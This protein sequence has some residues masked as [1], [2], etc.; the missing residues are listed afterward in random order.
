VHQPARTARIVR[1]DELDENADRLAHWLSRPVG[2]RIRHVEELR[3]MAVPRGSRDP[4][5]ELHSDHRDL[6][7]ILNAK[8]VAYVVVGGMAVA[9]HGAPRFTVDLDL[10]VHDSFANLR[11]LAN[12]LAQSGFAAGELA[13]VE[14]LD[15]TRA[16]QLGFEPWRIDLLSCLAG[17]TWDE[18]AAGAETGDFGVPAPVLGRAELIRNKR[19]VG[20][21]QDLADIARLGG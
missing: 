21:P 3:R 9:H 12:A 18:A 16:I 19:A 1:Q 5:M 2:E 6:L 14:F 8:G 10:F 7:A 4:S 13:E 15:S 17:I 20:R 11:Q